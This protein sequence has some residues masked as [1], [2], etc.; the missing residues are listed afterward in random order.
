MNTQ[1]DQTPG[2]N[3]AIIRIIIWSIVALLLL[4]LLA[5]GLSGWLFPSRERL[6]QSL[7]P[8]LPFVSG[9]SSGAGQSYDYAESDRYSI[10]AGSAAAA[11]IRSID[12]Q[13]IEGGVTVVAGEGDTI[14]FSEESRFELEDRYKMH[15]YVRNGTLYIQY[16]AS[17]VPLSFKQPLSKTLT[18]TIPRD[19][20]LDSFDLEA[21]SAKVEVDSVQ[22]DSIDIEAVSGAMEL[23]SL[24]AQTMDLETVSGRTRLSKLLVGSLSVDGVSGSLEIEKSELGEVECGMV[25]GTM[26]IEPGAG[27]RSIDASTVSGSIR[28]TLP[29]IPGFTARYAEGSGRF[30]SDFP[31]EFP[32]K[33]TA[34]YGDGSAEFEFSTIS[35]SIQIEKQ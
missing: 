29:E 7:L 3:S 35:G 8:E 1:P 11:D 2:R 6:A 19:H 31:V 14:T 10:G 4:A 24:T 18:V 30:K 22:A 12:I 26:R 20:Q 33:R 5:A 25:S 13:W 9:N 17:R 32:S 27:I 21:V 23:S 34:V 15:Y 16:C 28:I